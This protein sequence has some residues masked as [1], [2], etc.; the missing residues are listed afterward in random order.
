[1][2][3]LLTE[4]TLQQRKV[5]IERRHVYVHL[6]YI[7]DSRQTQTELMPSVF[8][9]NGGRSIVAVSGRSAGH[10]LHTGPHLP[11]ITSTGLPTAANT[12]P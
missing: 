9:P 2:I 6:L 3:L 4:Q 1:M 7:V 11:L 10:Y 8:I 5:D 12:S